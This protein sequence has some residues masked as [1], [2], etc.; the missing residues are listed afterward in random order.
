MEHYKCL[1]FNGISSVSDLL[2]PK[3]KITTKAD[4]RPFK[5]GS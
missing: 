1:V 2:P 4:V 3:L 5:F